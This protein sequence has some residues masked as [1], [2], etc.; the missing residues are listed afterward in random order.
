VSSVDAKPEP[1]ANRFYSKVFEAAHFGWLAGGWWR[2]VWVVLGLTPLAL[3]LTGVSTW[4]FRLGTK[5][6]RRRANRA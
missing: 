4:L 3:L 5:R 1:A 6:R 2:I